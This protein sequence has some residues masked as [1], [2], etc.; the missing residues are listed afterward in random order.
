M[1]KI[2][3][4]TIPVEPD[5]HAAVP[6]LQTGWCTALPVLRKVSSHS[7]KTCCAFQVALWAACRVPA[8]MKISSSPSADG[9]WNSHCQ[10]QSETLTALL[11]L[12]RSSSHPRAQGK[13]LNCAKHCWPC[14]INWDFCVTFR[15]ENDKIHMWGSTRLYSQPTFQYLHCPQGIALTRYFP[16][17]SGVLEPQQKN[18]KVVHL[19]YGLVFTP[20]PMWWK[21][22]DVF[23]CG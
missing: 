3:I 11:P 2:S 23:R 13:M 6:S 4:L 20:L 10:V 1:K 8:Q 16:Y 5:I 22:T 12:Q 17:L 14:L 18:L 7:R 9:G 15:I 21:S 19:F